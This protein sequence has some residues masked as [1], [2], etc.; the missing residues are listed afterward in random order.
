MH[1]STGVAD[2]EPLRLAL[3]IVTSLLPLRRYDLYRLTS[4]ASPGALNSSINSPKSDTP[5]NSTAHENRVNGMQTGHYYLR[6]CF[7]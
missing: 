1:L 4:L 3:W 7:P 6:D 2:M 5:I